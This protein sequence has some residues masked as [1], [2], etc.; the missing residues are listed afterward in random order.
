MA[1]IV[2]AF[3]RLVPTLASLKLCSV[4]FHEGAAFRST[5]VVLDRSLSSIPRVLGLWESSRSSTT[6]RY[7]FSTRMISC[8]TALR[9]LTSP[10]VPG[11]V[12]LLAPLQPSSC[13]SSGSRRVDVLVH[14][15]V[16]GASLVVSLCCLLCTLLPRELL[17]GFWCR[18]VCRDILWVCD[19]LPCALGIS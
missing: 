9:G 7:S 14:R 6:L 1:R 5:Q 15:V 12:V 3:L 4:D 11:F 2:W 19:S 8:L 10:S 16:M 18:H 13:G 17:Q